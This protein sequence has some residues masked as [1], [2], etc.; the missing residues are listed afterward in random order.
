[1]Q[2]ERCKV[3]GKRD[4]I[5]TSYTLRVAGYEHGTCNGFP[6]HGTATKGKRQEPKRLSEVCDEEKNDFTV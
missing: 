1:M 6:E 5:V 3:K 2:G 4:K